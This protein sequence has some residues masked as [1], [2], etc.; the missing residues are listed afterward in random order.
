MPLHKGAAKL[1]RA[2]LE[3]CAKGKKPR[4]TK[5]GNLSKAQLAAINADRSQRG[6]PPID[7]E[8]IFIGTHIHRS[9]C[10]GNGYT[11]E[12]VIEQITSAMDESSV[13][14]VTRRMTA[15]RNPAHR[16]DAYG[17]QVHDEVIFECTAR[18][19]HPE[20]FS[21]IPLGDRIKPTKK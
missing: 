16:N 7:A 11:I 4:P 20:L 3:L 14:Q 5:I 13:V 17:N 10:E 19:P 18:H 9:R 1:I 21:V 6:F 12:E 15:M 8:V 2:N